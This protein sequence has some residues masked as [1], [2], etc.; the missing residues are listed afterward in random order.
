[1]EK[2][3][4]AAH[5]IG[6][7]LA[8]LRDTAAGASGFL[9]VA[10][11]LCLPL[12]WNIGYFSHDELQW[13]AFADKP[14]LRDVPWSAWFDFSPFQYR[15]LTFNL[16]LLLSHYIGYQPIAMH[17]VRVLFGLG[18]AWLLR[19]VMLQ[20]DATRWQAT[21]AAW[22]W[23]LMPYTVYTHGWTGTY[24]DSLCLIFMLMALRF[25]LRQPT[26]SWRQSAMGAL[27]VAA[28]TSLALMS[29]E[30][31]IVFPAAIL[32]AA[33]RRRDRSVAAAFTASSIVVLIYLG[34]RLKTILFP[35]AVSSAYHWS[36]AN[37]PA[38][39]TEYTIFPFMVGHFEVIASRDYLTGASLLCL[40]IFAAALLST[41]WRRFAAFWLGWIVM[42]GPVLILAQSSN[43]YAYLAG[44]FACA[45]VGLLWSHG[46]R[47]ARFTFALVAAVTVAHGI[48]EAKE[49]RDI[50]RIQH[51]LYAD[52]M[53]LLAH[54]TTPIR[55][56]A[57]RN[58]DDFVLRRL[59]HDIPSFRRKP[60]M[61][62]VSVIS[63]ADKTDKPDYRMRADGHLIP[64]R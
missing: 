59:L 55:I 3:A 52:L 33:F 54:D 12:V 4:N 50:G 7:P 8:R 58:K 32:I 37:I 18:A 41:S 51:H 15:P 1:M 10:F 17:L 42:L 21:L 25:V 61:D 23:L 31:A 29:K 9:L 39:L 60:I 46:R 16:W 24:A 30:S 27:P 26:G 13:L 35:H 6:V 44:A 64:A 56:E 47:L 57:Q 2:L 5:R 14:S 43:H 28:L 19:S 36:L 62:R 49:M 22:I 20:F 48:Q 11:L 45:F 38:R 40:A 53:P 34:L 63:F